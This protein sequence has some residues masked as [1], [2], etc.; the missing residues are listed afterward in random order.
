MKTIAAKRG[1]KTRDIDHIGTS[2]DSR[3][4]QPSFRQ[5]QDIN[6][7]IC[8]QNFQFSQSRIGE[9]TSF[10]HMTNFQVFSFAHFLRMTSCNHLP[11]TGVRISLGTSSREDFLPLP[12]MTQSVYLLEVLFPNNGTPLNLARSFRVGPFPTTNRRHTPSLIGCPRSAFE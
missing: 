10:V 5:T 1:L 4:R 8:T 7:L 9:K 11:I 3:R 2:F 12:S 6:I